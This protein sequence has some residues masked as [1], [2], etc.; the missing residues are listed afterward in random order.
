MPADLEG[1]NVAAS[2]QALAGTLRDWAGSALERMNVVATLNLP[3]NGRYL[4]RQGMCCMLTYE[5]LIDTSEGSDLVFVPFSPR[6][7]AHQG[8]VWRA[9]TPNRQTQAFLDAVKRIC[10]ACQ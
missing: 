5:G 3:L 9:S 8:L 4:V 2:R 1:H 10:E 7:E 6:F